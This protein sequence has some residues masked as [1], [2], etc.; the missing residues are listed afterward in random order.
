MLRDTD[1]AIKRPGT[2]IDPKFYESILNKNARNQI[3]KDQVIS[4]DMIE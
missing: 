3:F 2:G 4:W 1:L